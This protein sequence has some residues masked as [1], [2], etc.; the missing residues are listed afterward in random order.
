MS[1]TGRRATAVLIAAALAWAPIG[2]VSGLGKAEQH[3]SAVPNI[4]RQ[5]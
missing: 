2:K 5:T 3:R 4:S 1:H